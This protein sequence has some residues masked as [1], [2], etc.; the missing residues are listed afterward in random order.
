MESSLESDC[1]EPSREA[2]WVF[3]APERRS[4]RVPEKWLFW[5]CV[6]FA[7]GSASRAKL[8]DLG[9]KKVHEQLP[10]T[11]LQP[12]T[13]WYKLP[14]QRSDA[15]SATLLRPEYYD[16]L[17]WPCI[18]SFSLCLCSSHPHIATSNKTAV[19]EKFFLLLGLF[20]R[21]EWQGTDLHCPDRIWFGVLAMR[22]IIN[23]QH[24]VGGSVSKKICI[25][26]SSLF[27][28]LDIQERV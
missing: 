13:T 20:Q 24:R 7:K 28:L 3:L 10:I 16:H 8:A 26:A 22:T 11:S 4:F 12:T 18:S 27:T 6:Y 19:T 9:R 21:L 25:L 14:S 1:S 17:I 15:T 5:S 2:G 23:P